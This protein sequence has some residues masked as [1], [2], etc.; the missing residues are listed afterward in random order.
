VAE[1]PLLVIGGP[2]GTGKSALSLDVAES[3]IASGHRVEIVNA[4]AMQL[5]RGMDIGTAKLPVA[6]R[7]GIPH[8]LFDV[9]DVAE[10]STVADYQTLARAAVDDIRER[11]GLP[12]VVG[13]SGLYISALIHDLRFPGTDAAVR[14]DLA[15]ELDR[16]GADAMWARLEAIDPEAARV[17]DRSNGRRV[18]RALE[19]IA[20]TGAPYSAIL[21]DR[22]SPWTPH[23]LVVLDVPFDER[24]ALK[25]RLGER[26][27]GMFRDGLVDETRA[28][29]GAG[30]RD[31]VTASRAIGYAQAIGVIDGALDEAAAIEET[32]ALTLRYVRR[33]RSW[34][35]RYDAAVRVTAV[36]ALPQ[37]L[38]MLPPT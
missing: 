23:T 1:S 6:E 3:L 20:I 15:S 38:A 24:P 21:P 34:F 36:D 28:L 7:R 11:G 13:G 10:V 27:A 31:G 16:E 37:T 29:L 18:I 26:V 14:A 35:G 9:L 2:T 22:T 4:D 5:Y 19:V 8:H 32:T 30:L 12:V 25:T 17:I 33:Q